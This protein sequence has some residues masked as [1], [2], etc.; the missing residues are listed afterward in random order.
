MSA[1]C[2][3][4]EDIIRNITELKLQC[5]ENEPNLTL[6]EGVKSLKDLVNF[7]VIIS[8]LKEI[9]FNFS[10]HDCALI[11]NLDLQMHNADL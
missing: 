8:L 10:V 7:I 4:G 6:L 11:L 2:S 3:L 1:L 9:L 5:M